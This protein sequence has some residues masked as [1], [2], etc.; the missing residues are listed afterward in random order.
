MTWADKPYR[1]PLLRMNRRARFLFPPLLILL[2][3][4]TWWSLREPAPDLIAHQFAGPTMG[5]TWSVKLVTGTLTS[6]ERD[7]IVS[8]D[9]LLD[10][11]WNDR[12][13]SDSALSSRIMSARKAVGDGGKEQ[14]L[15]KTV[16]GRGF[17]FLG[18]V[19]VGSAPQLDVSKPVE[20]VE[21]SGTSWTYQPFWFEKIRMG[22]E[23][24]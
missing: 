20:R 4:L 1:T 11:V 3:A 24:L 17:R 6:A 16:H 15:I 21:K 12:Y 2:V 22:M 23:K 7:K 8:R 14:R 5:T 18:E 19:S 10:N 9:D 13:V